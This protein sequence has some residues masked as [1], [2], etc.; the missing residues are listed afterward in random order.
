MPDRARARTGLDVRARSR[1]CV[2]QLCCVRAT[3]RGAIE[4]PA[5]PV[6]RLSFVRG[7]YP[8]VML[9]L[10]LQGGMLHGAC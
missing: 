7:L 1:V 6:G 3:P 8:A 5:R 10:V 2:S 4:Q 9:A